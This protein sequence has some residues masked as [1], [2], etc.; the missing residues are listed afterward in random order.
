MASDRQKWIHPPGLTDQAPGSQREGQGWNP[1]RWRQNP[2]PWGPSAL[3]HRPEPCCGGARRNRSLQ[4]SRGRWHQ[5]VLSR[6][7]SSERAAERG[8]R[9]GSLG[10]GSAR[11]LRCR[12]GAGLH[13]EAGSSGGPGGCRGGAAVQPD[14][15]LPLF[16]CRESSQRPSL[17][18]GFLICKMESQRPPCEGSE[19]K[20]EPEARTLLPW[21]FPVSAGTGGGR[22]QQAPPCGCCV[23]GAPPTGPGR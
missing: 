9:G 23:G 3:G 14:L 19:G 21:T 12:E 11:S 16:P 18:L 5:A 15:C 8:V 1:E 2:V 13:L 22:D 7:Q 17:S 4:E 20:W 10:E 6:T